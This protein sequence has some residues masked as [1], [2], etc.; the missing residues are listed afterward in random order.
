[1]NLKFVLAVLIEISC[2]FVHCEGL[3]NRTILLFVADLIK[4]WSHKH[5]VSNNVVVINTGQTTEPVNFLLEHI[6]RNIPT[7]LANASDCEK[8][9]SRESFVIISSHVFNSVILANF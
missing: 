4:D 2:F 1:M 8:I 6:A 9:E 5:S 7:V 3:P